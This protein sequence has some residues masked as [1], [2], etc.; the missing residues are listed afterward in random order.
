V[1]G[2]RGARR[3]LAL[4]RQHARLVRARLAA[5]RPGPEELREPAYGDYIFNNQAEAAIAPAARGAMRVLMALE[6]VALGALALWPGLRVFVQARLA[7][8]GEGS[9]A[10][11]GIG[12]LSVF[13]R[14]SAQLL[15][16][17]QATFRSVRID[18]LLPGQGTPNVPRHLPG[19]L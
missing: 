4:R 19:H 14:K 16:L 13:G 8:L 1:A 10:A 5:R 3:D 15:D 2:A 11:A 18:R 9:A 7:S 12:A 17:G 6:L